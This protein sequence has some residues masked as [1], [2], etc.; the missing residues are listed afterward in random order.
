MGLLDL[1]DESDNVIGHADYTRIHSEGLRHRSVNV[2][3]IDHGGNLAVSERSGKQDV[4]A[5]KFHPSVGGHP[6]LG[7]SYGFAVLDQIQDELFHD[8][9]LPPGLEPREIA[10][11]KNDTRST[12]KENTRLYIVEYSGQF[13]LNPK[14]TRQILWRS[15]EQIVD[16]FQDNEDN[17]TQTFKS[18]FHEYLES[19]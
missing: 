19:S 4:S 18:A 11:Y 15:P 14:E 16:D 10:R 6:R 7:Q 3:F 9:D 17:Y 13:T 8:Q 12:N 1:V 5:Y 2:W